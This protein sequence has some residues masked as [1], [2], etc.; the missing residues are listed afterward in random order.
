MWPVDCVFVSSVIFANRSLW[1][2]CS[3]RS[4][5]MTRGALT[6][7]PLAGEGSAGSAH[8]WQPSIEEELMGSDRP[9][10]W[11][12]SCRDISDT[13]VLRQA[14]CAISWAPSTQ[15]RHGA[16]Q[17]RARYMSLRLFLWERRK[18]QGQ[19]H[20]NIT[21]LMWWRCGVICVTVKHAIFLLS[22]DYY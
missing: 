1:S 3:R 7:S 13:N 2:V 4:A 17:R 10:K 18:Y 12:L 21:V 9:G 20:Q 6:L 11:S 14:P 16:N 15:T 5:V 22:G 19:P 8:R